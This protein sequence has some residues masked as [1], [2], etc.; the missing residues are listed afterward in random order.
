LK[1]DTNPNIRDPAKQKFT[2]SRHIVYVL[3]KL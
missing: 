3:W 2:F 1:L